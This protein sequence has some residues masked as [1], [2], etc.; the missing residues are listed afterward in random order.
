MKLR[1][2]AIRIYMDTWKPFGANPTPIAFEEVFTALQQGV[3]TGQENPVTVIY[4]NH[5]NEVCKYL[6]LTNHAAET[7]GVIFNENWWQKLTP[8]ERKAIETAAAAT[9]DWLR[10]FTRQNETRQIDELRTKGMTVISPDVSGFVA[11]GRNVVIDPK[12]EPWVKRFQA[13]D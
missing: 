7:V 13:L 10:D 1:V 4:D 5:F 9:S 12:L 6:I 8:E 3:V 11:R 2:P